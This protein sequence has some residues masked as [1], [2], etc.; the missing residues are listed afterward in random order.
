MQYFTR[1]SITAVEKHTLILDSIY[2]GLGS[3]GV[4][5]KY[6]KDNYHSQLS[7]LQRNTIILFRV[8]GGCNVGQGHQVMVH[9]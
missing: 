6:V 3:W 5:Q 2:Q 1:P 4:Q 9:A 7:V 8:N